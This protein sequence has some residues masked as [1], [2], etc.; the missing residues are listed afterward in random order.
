MTAPAQWQSGEGTGLGRDGKLPS[1]IREHSGDLTLGCVKMP[2]ARCAN[3]LP[4][5]GHLSLDGDGVVLRR[6]ES[7]PYKRAKKGSTRN[8]IMTPRH[9]SM[10]GFDLN[11]NFDLE[12]KSDIRIRIS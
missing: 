6:R 2:I 8:W 5:F 3:Q 7:A 9:Q 12:S 10:F 4:T 11:L 1:H